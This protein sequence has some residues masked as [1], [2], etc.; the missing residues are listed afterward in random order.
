AA[1]DGED[2]QFASAL[3]LDDDLEMDDSEAE[4]TVEGT[5]ASATPV[6]VQ[7]SMF[8]VDIEVAI[9]KVGKVWLITGTEMAY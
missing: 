2:E 7:S 8:D 9:K 1:R 6:H 5:E 3:E 4:I